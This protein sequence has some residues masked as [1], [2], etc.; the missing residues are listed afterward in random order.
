MT[1]FLRRS[2]LFLFYCVSFVLITGLA[3]AQTVTVTPAEGI[4]GVGQTQQFHAAVTGLWNSSVTWSLLGMGPVNNP[5]LGSIDATG[6]YT[7]PAKIP[8]QNPVTI[9]ATGSDGKTVGIGYAYLEPLGPTLTSIS[10]NT[11]PVNGY[12]PYTVTITGSTFQQGAQVFA[13]PNEISVASVTSTKIV[14]NGAWNAPG[15]MAFTVKNPGTTVSNGITVTFV[16][17]APIT[18][19]PSTATVPLGGTK[20][21][22]ATGQPSVTWTASAGTIVARSSDH[23]RI[24]HGDHH[25]FRQR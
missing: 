11:I 1:K 4:L 12:T 24:E 13:G 14:A 22:M 20:Q 25:S 10:P 3:A 8:G 19:S 23:A 5:V 17:S 15:T 9:R 21:F 2:T 6:L 18:L 7:A 16:P